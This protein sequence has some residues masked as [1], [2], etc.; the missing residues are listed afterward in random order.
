MTDTPKTPSIPFAMLNDYLFNEV[1]AQLHPALRQYL[2][3]VKYIQHQDGSEALTSIEQWWPVMIPYYICTPWY[4]SDALPIADEALVTLGK[5]HLLY[6]ADSILSDNLV[7]GQ[8]EQVAGP[9]LVTSQLRVEGLRYWQMLFAHD[10]PFWETYHQTERNFYWGLAHELNIVEHK[11][12]PHTI[13]DYLKV[14]E[15]KFAIYTRMLHALRYLSEQP[16]N[17]QPM[18]DAFRGLFVADCLFDDAADWQDDAQAGRRTLPIVLA[19]QAT[20]TP[21]ER[22]GELSL[23]ELEARINRSN[24]MPRITAKAIDYLEKA[25]TRLREAGLDDTYF[26]HLLEQR[27][28]D[29]LDS[30]RVFNVVRGFDSFITA[31]N[32]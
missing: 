30:H 10:H 3:D 32:R 24:I 6:F 1:M 15:G 5:G 9:Y 4:F 26:A 28:Q 19:L 23:P 2:S 12:A 16:D 21:L 13:E 27:Y 25:R 11:Q 20:N 31:L 8:L 22:F 14:C 18:L 17:M 29:A 7:D